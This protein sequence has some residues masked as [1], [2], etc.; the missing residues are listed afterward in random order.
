[1]IKQI[2]INNNNSQKLNSMTG[3]KCFSFGYK[4]NKKEQEKRNRKKQANY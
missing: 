3:S 2:K 4:D 1:M